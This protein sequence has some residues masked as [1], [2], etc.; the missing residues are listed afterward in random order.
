MTRDTSAS[1]ASILEEGFA[2]TTR[3]NAAQDGA[4]GRL[5]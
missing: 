2:R 5:R 1:D 4:V 3:I